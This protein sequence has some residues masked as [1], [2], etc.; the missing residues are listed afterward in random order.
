MVTSPRITS[1]T[2]PPTRTS[3]TLP[4][5]RVARTRIRLGR[6]I[7]SPYSIITRSSLAATPFATIHAA[8][9]PAADPVAGSSPP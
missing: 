7:S 9:Q 3:N 5:S 1:T 6:A 2:C 8:A 4:R